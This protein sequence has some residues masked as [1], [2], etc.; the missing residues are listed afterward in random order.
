MI[1]PNSILEA[2]DILYGKINKS[3]LQPNYYLIISVIQDE[4]HLLKLSSDIMPNSF[5]LK[6]SAFSKAGIK[7]IYVDMDT[8]FT[9]KKSDLLICFQDGDIAP[10]KLTTN[11][12]Y[13][14]LD[15]INNLT[16][17]SQTKNQSIKT[18]DSSHP[19]LGSFITWVFLFSLVGYFLLESGS[20]TIWIGYIVGL[21]AFLYIYKK[22]IAKLI[23]MSATVWFCLWIIPVIIPDIGDMI[24]GIIDVLAP[25]VSM[26]VAALS[27]NLFDA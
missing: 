15:N 9:L 16:N 14:V 24:G 1:A 19:S 12:V 23:L 13:N 20:P 4:Y 8:S 5:K 27:K 21:F 11:E 2:G 3:E 17:N 10:Y 25:P 22:L 18:S 7:N 26:F 6:S